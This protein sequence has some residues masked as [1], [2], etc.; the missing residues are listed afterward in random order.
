M[1]HNV[2][3][4]EE[5]LG[6]TIKDNSKTDRIRNQMNINDLSNP[7]EEDKSL[8]GPSSTIKN[9]C[10]AAAITNPSD[11]KSVAISSHPP[12]TQSQSFQQ[13]TTTSEQNINNLNDSGSQ[14]TMKKSRSLP[15]NYPVTTMTNLYSRL[16]TN[17]NNTT[18]TNSG[19]E[20]NNNNNNNNN[21]GK[22]DR[23]IPHVVSPES[24]VLHRLHREARDASISANRSSQL[25]NQSPMISSQPLPGPQYQ[26]PLSIGQPILLQQP[27]PLP[28]QRQSIYG[29][30]PL[31]IPQQHGPVP[32]Q[33]IAS[34]VSK[35]WSPQNQTAM[36]TPNNTSNNSSNNNINNNSY[37]NSNSDNH[38]M[39]YNMQ[40]KPTNNEY[41][42]PTPSTHRSHNNTP[43]LRDNGTANNMNNR[44]VIAPESMNHESSSDDGGVDGNNGNSHSDENES[45]YLSKKGTRRLRDSKRAVQNRNAQKA[46]RQRKEKYV[47][48]LENKALKYDEL[49]QE[50]VMLHREN[51]ELKNVIFQLDQRLQIFNDYYLNE[52]QQQ[53]T[54]FQSQKLA[55]LS[56]Q[57]QPQPQQAVT[58][59]PPQ[60]GQQ[61]QP[62]QQ[63]QPLPIYIMQPQASPPGPRPSL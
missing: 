32:S 12:P 14:L 2:S 20:E 58:Q 61:R 35:P 11:A 9:L 50:N 56:P 19:H 29:V 44:N 33:G 1:E 24:H 37:N 53:P 10:D 62:P 21:N 23:V 63:Y 15:K 43:N 18:L 59:P 8:P 40:Q 30:P 34:L 38:M 54:Q 13:L 31:S 39:Q 7:V 3:H 52:L 45:M 16:Q 47:R 42:G 17:S 28:Q 49:M 55:P 4:H 22:F 41:G 36:I 48:L 51:N 26:Q 27:P 57:A 60:V 25:P 6:N 5:K 46:F